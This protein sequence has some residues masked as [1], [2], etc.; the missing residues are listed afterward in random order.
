MDDF[1]SKDL[2]TSEQTAEVVKFILKPPLGVLSLVFYKVLAKTAISTLT[3]EQRQILG[4]KSV[5]K[6]WR[7]I[8]AGLLNL[9]SFALGKLSPSQEAAMQRIE[10]SA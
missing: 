9:L 2:R 8:C 5:S 1:M 3:P 7:V 4:L 6:A 10:R